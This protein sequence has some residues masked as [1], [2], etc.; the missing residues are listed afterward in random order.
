MVPILVE[1]LALLSI[2]LRA[3]ASVPT[4]VQSPCP[5]E[6]ASVS[7]S[8]GFI[9]F[10]RLYLRI[11]SPAC[12]SSYIAIEP[13]SPATV[14]RTRVLSNLVGG[15]TSDS[16]FVLNFKSLS[17]PHMFGIPEVLDVRSRVQVHK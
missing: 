11:L 1:A 2:L 7:G 16:S 17:S 9:L 15:S 13:F 5:Y 14:E 6:G 4:V 3:D 12:L 8:E 10:Y